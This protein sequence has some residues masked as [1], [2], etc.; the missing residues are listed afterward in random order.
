MD[1]KRPGQSILRGL[2][3]WLRRA[4]GKAGM[5]ADEESSIQAICTGDNEETG[6]DEPETTSFG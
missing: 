2:R 4:F 3:A 6:F 5:G 1:P